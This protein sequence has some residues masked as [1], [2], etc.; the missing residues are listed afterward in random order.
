MK[1]IFL[2]V[3]LCFSGISAFSSTA[4]LENLL[5]K[6]NEAESQKLPQTALTHAMELEKKAKAEKHKGLY[7]RALAKR[8]L[9]QSHILG[10]APKDK[11]KILR[12][13][14]GKI[15]EDLRP[16]V[17]IIL[18]RWFWHYYEQNRYKFS[19]RTQTIGLQSDDFTT[20]DLNKIFAEVRAL[21][22]DGLRSADYLKKEEIEDY[23]G[24]IER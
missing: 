5:T 15:S 4:D 10:K 17:K 6:I 24:V 22:E 23:N 3:I 20:W 8:I 9:N 12:E 11:V 1:D 19:D 14:V 18:A 13:E 21:F 7:V 16:L 2:A